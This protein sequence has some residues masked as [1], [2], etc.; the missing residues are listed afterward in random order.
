MPT[1]QN[2]ERQYYVYIMANA[3]HKLYI[4]LTNDLVRRVYEHRNKLADGH[5]KKYN[6]TMLMYYESTTDVL[7]A[8]ARE[9]QL[10]GWNRNKKDALIES[11]NPRWVDLAMEWYG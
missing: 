7:A 2:Q 1:N 3:R 8:I 6:N 10:K 5:T 9:K 11:F 4:G